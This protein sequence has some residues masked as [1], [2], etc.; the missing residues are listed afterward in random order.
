MPT[1][2]APVKLSSSSSAA[3]ASAPAHPS[4]GRRS[5]ISPSAEYD[6]NASATHLSPQPAAP[7][8]RRSL[9]W[10]LAA[11]LAAALLLSLFAWRQASH[12]PTRNLV[13]LSLWIPAGQQLDL[14]SGPSVVISPDGSRL[15]Y[16][17]AESGGAAGA[18]LYVR[19][20]D[21]VDALLLDGA[22]SAQAQ[23]FSPDSQWIGFYSRR[24][25]EENLGARRRADCL[26]R[27]RQL[28]RRG[29]GR[30][31][32]DYFPDAIHQPAV[33]R[34]RGRRHA[35]ASDASGSRAWGDHA[36]L[37]ATSPRR[38]SGPLHRVVG[39]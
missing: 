27:R 35:G 31:R 2:D 6:P 39:Q 19:D 15:A 11:I 1:E 34:V 3:H 36:P 33:P 24:K 16:V 18:Q 25:T 9:P 5:A 38:K 26:V 14:G 7:P 22:G 13:E 28:S 21:K 37:A 23:F 4:S 20:L 29:L 32:D 8:W 17:A 12:P 10:A 30:R